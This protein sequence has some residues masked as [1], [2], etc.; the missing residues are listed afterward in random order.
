MQV[1][2]AGFGGPIADHG[3]SSMSR[4]TPSNLFVVAKL[5]RFWT[6]CAR[7][8]SLQAVPQLLLPSP[9]IWTSVLMP[10]CACAVATHC[11]TLMFWMLLLSSAGPAEVAR[12]NSSTWVMSFQGMF[13]DGAQ[14]RSTV[15]T[16]C[17]DAEDEAAPVPGTIPTMTATRTATARVAGTS[18]RRARGERRPLAAQAAAR[19]TGMAAKYGGDMGGG[20]CRKRVADPIGGCGRSPHQS[21]E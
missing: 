18:G 4:S 5:M 8:V 2:I 3:P 11:G 21:F 14:P 7:F 10:G 15:T 16:S 19:I 20:P 1:G 17:P 12:L 13:G 6:N 9:P